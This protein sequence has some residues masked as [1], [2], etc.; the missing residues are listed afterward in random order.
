MKLNKVCLT[1]LFLRLKRR[2]IFG[3]SIIFILLLVL[4]LTWPD[5]LVLPGLGKGLRRRSSD[6]DSPIRSGQYSEVGKPQKACSDRKKRVNAI[7]EA[8]ELKEAIA[9]LER[10]LLP[11]L[12]KFEPPVGKRYHTC[13]FTVTRNEF[14]LT[15]FIVRNLLAGVDHIW[16]ADDNRVRPIWP[17][18]LDFR[19]NFI[20]PLHLL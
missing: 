12:P 17:L 3:V 16:I 15:E 11:L 10:E 8:A 13:V 19:R 4:Y 18:V 7:D 1:N 20:S 9:I 5:S 6:S 2:P 14:Y